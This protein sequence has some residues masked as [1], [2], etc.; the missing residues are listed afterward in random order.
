MFRRRSSRSPTIGSRSP[1]TLR[2]SETRASGEPGAVH[3]A[4]ARRNSD[5]LGPV[6]LVDLPQLG[7]AT[8]SAPVIPAS[9]W[10][11]TEQKNSYVPGR[12]AERAAEAVA[13]GA[14]GREK[15]WAGT[16]MSWGRLPWFSKT[17]FTVSPAETLTSLGEKEDSRA[18]TVTSAAPGLGEGATLPPDPSPCIQACMELIQPEPIQFRAGFAEPG[19]AAPMAD[20]DT[21]P[22]TPTT[23]RMSP[24]LFEP[25]VTTSRTRPRP[26]SCSG[27]P[28]RRS[29]PE[30][31]ARPGSARPTLHPAG[32]PGRPKVRGPA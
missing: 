24:N 28:P 16:V 13:P 15:P 27:T 14:A 25:I 26:V 32:T 31:S 7:H 19:T 4:W 2:H 6:L 23:T 1:T 10:P 22:T 8:P 21:S 30:R 20:R 3:A 17:R 12:A 11:G 9:R 18:T 5:Q 29:R